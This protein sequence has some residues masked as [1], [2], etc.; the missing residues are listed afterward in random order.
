MLRSLALLLLIASA[1]SLDAK[2]RFWSYTMKGTAYDAR[3][4]EPLKDAVIIIGR[5]TVTTNAEGYYNVTVNGV[6]C[7]K[8][9]RWRIN[10][11]N[12]RAYGHLVLQR[13]GESSSTRIKSHWKKYAFCNEQEEDCPPFIKDLFVP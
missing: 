2:G 7:D 3:T 5:D 9:G 6:T 13:L 8:G 10:R 12:K 1:N 4:K 11:C